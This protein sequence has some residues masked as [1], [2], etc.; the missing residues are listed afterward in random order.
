[1]GKQIDSLWFWHRSCQT[2]VTTFLLTLVL[3]PSADAAPVELNEGRASK[4]VLILSSYDVHH[5]GNTIVIQAIRATSGKNSQERIHAYPECLGSFQIPVVKYEE[6]LIAL[7]KQTYEGEP[8]DLIIVLGLPALKVW[9]KHRTNLQPN[10]P[11]SFKA[12]GKHLRELSPRVLR[13]ERPQDIATHRITSI[14]MFAWRKLRP[15]GIHERSLPWGIFIQF[16]RLSFWTHY[17]FYIF[18]TIAISIFEAMLIVGL[19]INRARRRQAEA[20]SHRLSQLAEARRRHLDEVISNIPGLVWEIRADQGE[21]SQ[22]HAFVSDYVEK[23]LG[24]STQERLSTPDFWLS[25]I[26]EE[27]RDLVAHDA[28]QV[29]ADGKNR[30]R[31]FRWTAEDGRQLWAEMHIAP[32]F[33]E[34]GAA[35]GLR[36]VT[37]DITKHKLTELTLHQSEEKIKDILRAM[38]DLTFTQTPDGVYLDYYSKDKGKL[39]FLPEGFLGKSM[40]EVLP[41]ELAD[42]FSKCFKR[43]TESGELQIHEYMLPMQGDILWYEA[44]II[45]MNNGQ[46]LSVVRDITERKRA[47]AQLLES[48]ERFRNMTDSAPVMTWVAGHDRQRNYFNKQWL[49]FRGR[50]LSEELGFGWTEGVHAED[51]ERCIQT[52]EAAFKNRVPFTLEY[53]LRRADGV[54]RWIYESG[55][56]RLSQTEKFLGYI[57]SCLDLTDSKQTEAVYRVSQ[58]QLAGII[59][60]AMEAII[61]IDDNQHV[62]LFNTAAEEMFGCSVQEATGHSINRFLPERFRKQHHQLIHE[63]GE[64]K[65]ARRTMGVFGAIFGLRANG[66]EFPIEASISQTELKGKKFYTVIL[67]DI[68]ARQQAEEALRE[69]EAN[70]RAIFNGVNVAIFIHEKETAEILDVNQ[71][72]C[73]MFGVTAEE[74]KGLNVNVL[75]ANELPYTQAVEWIRCAAAGQPQLFEWHAKDKSGRTFWAEV[76]LRCIKLRG[77]ECVLAMVQDISNRKQ[78]EEAREEAFAQVSMLK[79]QLEA[80]NIYLQ[81]EIRLEY[82]FNEIIGKSTAIKNVFLKIEQVAPTNTTV[83]ILGETGTGKELVA[84]AIHSTSLRKDKVLVKV[85]CAALPAALIESEL[86]GHERGAFTSAT[87][88][89]LGRFELANGGTIFLDEIGDLPPELQVKLLRVLQEGEFERLGS[90]KTIRVNV[91]VI[92]ATNRHLAQE[93]QNGLFREDLWYRLNVFPITVPPLRDRLEDIP[94]LVEAFVQRF[95]KELGKTVKAI[96]PVMMRALQEYSW[97]GNIRELANI[98]ERAVIHTDDSILRLADPLNRPQVTDLPFGRQTLEE[99]ERQYILRVLQETAW[100]IEGPKGAAQVLGLNPSTLRTRMAKLRIPKQ[101]D[102][103]Q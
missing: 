29:L 72:M 7:F 65:V 31:Q 67:R 46:I 70:Y 33:D 18:A 52:Y 42:A 61:T 55:V 40:W 99:L 28:H 41:A 95:A 90:G 13:G 19:L 30:V 83:L 103:W 53:R 14:T 74:V 85:N 79:S 50:K 16:K 49:D 58:A 11:I 20:T 27:D 68:A 21:N 66:E 82:N 39:M 25:I 69:S 102:I 26:P 86:F 62:V 12:I 4:K 23:K 87:T 64:T 80:E 38:P 2:F 84:R 48:E 5:P 34:L 63:Y 44:R 37:I 89:Q 92:A 43:A 36:G 93:V 91:R 57:G 96:T 15:W 97:P 3:V 6:A 100:R 45:H 98:I 9:L 59:G 10:A 51:Y 75:S 88:R 94:L 56:A 24:Y 22:A 54:F 1:M 32:I 78:A 8:F 77:K 73:E 71:R 17:E 101:R 60:S 81:E 76:S 47:E 35:V